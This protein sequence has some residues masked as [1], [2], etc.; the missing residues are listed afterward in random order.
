LFVNIGSG[1]AADG[2]DSGRCSLHVAD[3]DEGLV[4][5]ADRRERL[6][7]RAFL[8]L[9]PVLATRSGL[10]PDRYFSVVFA[11]KLPRRIVYP[12]EIRS[13]PY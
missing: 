7:A 8:P 9:E 4:V 3:L 13:R 5:G 2:A 6:R 11:K 1:P 12:D 10:Q